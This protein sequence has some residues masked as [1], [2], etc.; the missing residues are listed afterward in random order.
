MKYATR[1]V[2][3]RKTGLNVAKQIVWAISKSFFPLFGFFLT[4]KLYLHVKY[5]LWQV[6][7]TEMG[8]NDTSGVIWAFSKKNFFLFVFIDT[9]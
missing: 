8:P 3:T 2:D 9:N 5:K 7:T 1:K 6:E 4:N